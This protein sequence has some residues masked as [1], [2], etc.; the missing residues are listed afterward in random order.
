MVFIYFSLHE[1]NEKNLDCMD[2]KLIV[3]D[4]FLEFFHI[5][6]SIKRKFL[7]SSFPSNFL[8]ARRRRIHIIF[9]NIH[10]P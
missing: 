7:Q 3:H 10:T 1:N 4:V 8:F 2:I 5:N 6:N 9:P